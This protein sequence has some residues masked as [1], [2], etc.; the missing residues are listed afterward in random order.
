[1]GIATRVAPP[2][3]YALAN[4]KVYQRFLCLAFE[5]LEKAVCTPALI[6]DRSAKVPAVFL[7]KFI[8]KY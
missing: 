1:M 5:I 3:I 2:G 8:G 7:C 6:S 4:V